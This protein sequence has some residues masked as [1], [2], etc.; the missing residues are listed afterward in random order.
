MAKAH[1]AEY[2]THGRD[3]NVAVRQMEKLLPRVQ[4]DHL[5]IWQ[6]HKVIY[7]NDRDLILASNG[8]AEVLLAAKRQGL[9]AGSDPTLV[10]PE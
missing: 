7:E 5:D 3:K 9:L 4:S 2:C 6:I 8:V 1:D 10:Q